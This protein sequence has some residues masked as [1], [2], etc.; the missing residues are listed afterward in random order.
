MGR[1][2]RKWLQYGYHLFV[3]VVYLVFKIFV[4]WSASSF[5]VTLHIFCLHLLY[6]L[7]TFSVID[8]NFIF[9]T[10]DSLS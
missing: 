7:F 5:V 9:I 3:L 10:S 6:M 1:F 4:T 2:G 8:T